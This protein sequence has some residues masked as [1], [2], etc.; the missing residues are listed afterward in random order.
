MPRTL[1]TGGAGFIGLHLGRALSERGHDIDLLD[2][3]SRAVKDPALEEFLHRPGVRLLERDLAAGPLDD[4][5]TDYNYI[6]H[7]AALLGVRNVR[8]RPFEVLTLNH[9][10]LERALGLARRQKHLARFLFSSSSEVYAGTLRYFGMPIPTPDSTPL[11]LD[12]PGEPRTSYMLS[13]IHGEALCRYSGLPYSI[14]RVHNAYGPRMGLSHVVPELLRKAHD[15]TPGTALEVFSASHRRTFCFVADIVEFIARIMET[16]ACECQTLNI[17]TESPDISM[18][19]LGA[20]VLRTVGLDAPVAA[21][22]PSPGSPERRAP[23]MSRTIRLVQYQA[24]TALATGLRVTYDW[25]AAN[26]F[27]EAGASAI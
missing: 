16:P 15:L 11:A 8:N 25:Y 26:V 3:F 2:S 23:E 20:L 12:D 9:A 4:L 7:L 22:P 13:K 24:S 5:E 1:I 18:G 27:K 14:F 21:L 19:E 6:V 10:M 17:G